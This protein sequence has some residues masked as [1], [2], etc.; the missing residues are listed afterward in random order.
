MHLG[1]KHEFST[2]RR[3]LGVSGRSGGSVMID[4]ESL[5]HVDEKAHLRVIAAPYRMPMRSVD[6]RRMSF[7]ARPPA[8]PPGDAAHSTPPPL[9]ELRRHVTRKPPSG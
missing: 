6:S 3:T 8:Q 2:F 9:T 7:D 5:T 4:E 1:K